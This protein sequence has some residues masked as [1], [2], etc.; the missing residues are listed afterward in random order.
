MKKTTSQD[1]A[2]AIILSSLYPKKIL[3]TEGIRI[4]SIHPWL[5]ET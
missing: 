4:Q 5:E 1:R 2:T 3:L